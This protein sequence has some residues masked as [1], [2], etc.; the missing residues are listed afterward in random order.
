MERLPLPEC[1]KAC[2]CRLCYDIFLLLLLTL[3]QA[4]VSG[5]QEQARAK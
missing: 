3:T 4:D 5:T 1:S 2:L